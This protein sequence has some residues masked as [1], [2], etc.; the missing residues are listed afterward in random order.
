MSVTAAAKHFETEATWK[1]VPRS[2]PGLVNVATVSPLP[3]AT[4]AAPVKP[5]IT[6]RP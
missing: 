5:S 6:V 3:S 4:S 2:T 1:R